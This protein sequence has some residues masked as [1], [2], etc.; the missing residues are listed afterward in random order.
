MVNYHITT[1]GHQGDWIPEY[2]PI[3]DCWVFAENFPSEISR[4]IFSIDPP[5][6]AN[7]SREQMASFIEVM[8]ETFGCPFHLLTG[9]NEFDRWRTPAQKRL[10]R[11]NLEKEGYRIE[12]V[13]GHAVA[14]SSPRS[15]ID[16]SLVWE[17]WNRNAYLLYRTKD[18]Q[19]DVPAAALQ[20]LILSVARSHCGPRGEDLVQALGHFD[21]CMYCDRFDE[22]MAGIVVAMSNQE[23]VK[24][25]VAESQKRN[26]QE[27]TALEEGF[28]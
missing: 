27:W 3:T 7:D 11:R 13:D 28:W 9:W 18:H 1:A 26:F 6:I 19:G 2:D 22:Y 10:R 12:I 16:E 20:P 15:S 14:M 21:V 23:L 24:Q 25:L 5:R 4:M 8:N 17:F